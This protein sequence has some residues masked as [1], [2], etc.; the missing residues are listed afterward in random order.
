MEEIAAKEDKIKFVNSCT[1]NKGKIMDFE[2]AS[3]ENTCSK[4]SLVPQIGT[5]FTKVAEEDLLIEDQDVE[6]PIKDIS[7]VDCGT[8]EDC[9]LVELD[10]ANSSRVE[11]TQEYKDPLSITLLQDGRSE[12]FINELNQDNNTSKEDFVTSEEDSDEDFYEEEF[13]RMQMPRMQSLKT[14]GPNGEVKITQIPA[15][16]HVTRIPESREDRLKREQEIVRRKQIARSVNSDLQSCVR[17]PIKRKH[18]ER[19]TLEDVKRDDFEET[20]DYVDFLQ[21]KLKNISIKQC[22]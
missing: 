14:I 17:S 22:K 5:E 6:V 2:Q 19:M 18:S 1:D 7:V 21:S 10:L 9:S 16:I 15:S 4:V 11:A 20:Q 12:S 13:K 8:E 3:T